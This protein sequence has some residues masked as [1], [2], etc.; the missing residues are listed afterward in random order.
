MKKVMEKEK[1]QCGNID[2]LK[3]ACP[4]CNKLVKKG[5]FCNQC[6]KKM[7]EICNCWVLRKQYNCGQDKCKG[8]NLI[9]EAIKT[10]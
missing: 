10:K 4:H 6:G 2:V 3:V 5:N 7:V 1:R 8:L 9:T